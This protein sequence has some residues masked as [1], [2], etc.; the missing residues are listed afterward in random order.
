MKSCK[1][2]AHSIFDETWGEWKCG[3]FLRKGITNP[4][5]VGRGCKF[6]KERKEEKK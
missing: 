3:F 6:Y 1:N 2:C 5:L 4:D